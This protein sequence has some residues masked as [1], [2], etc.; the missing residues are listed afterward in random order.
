[1]RAAGFALGLVLAPILVFPE[2]VQAAGVGDVESWP[3]VLFFAQGLLALSGT[4]GG[5][6]WGRKSGTAA[7]GGT[8]W[9]RA[10]LGR[11]RG[12]AKA[13]KLAREPMLDGFPD[14]PSG[15]DMPGRPSPPLGRDWFTKL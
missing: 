6:R 5:A 8:A 1:L 3:M 10:A 15:P 11:T 4:H 13:P 12:A 2:H 14:R 7:E 9:M